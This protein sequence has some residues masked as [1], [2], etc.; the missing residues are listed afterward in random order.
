M[1]AFD[2][3]GKTK[4]RKL[5]LAEEKQKDVFKELRQQFDVSTEL[6]EELEKFVCILLWSE[7]RQEEHRC[8]EIHVPDCLK[9]FKT[10]TLYVK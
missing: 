10:Y 3:N 5:M 4:A 8:C 2:G 1:S 6:Q 9:L 7:A